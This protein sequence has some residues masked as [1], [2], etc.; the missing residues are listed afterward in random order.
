ME[1]GAAFILFG[2]RV[3]A[4]E[5]FETPEFHHEAPAF[6]YGSLAISGRF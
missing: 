4:T 6:Q 2:V 1:V 3:T 5:I